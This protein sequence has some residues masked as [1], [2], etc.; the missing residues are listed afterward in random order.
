[1][2]LLERVPVE[3]RRRTGWILP[4]AVASLIGEFVPESERVIGQTERLWSG[5]LTL[6]GLA[7]GLLWQWYSPRDVAERLLFPSGALVVFAV[8]FMLPGEW[9]TS[10][11]DFGFWFPFGVVAGL[12]LMGRW[13]RPR[14]EVREEQSPGT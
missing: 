4:I 7:V 11:P 1:M 5:G 6:A 14:T 3:A 10:S 13:Q 2:A 12:V 9:T 8:I